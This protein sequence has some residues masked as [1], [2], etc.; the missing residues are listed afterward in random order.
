MVGDTHA[1]F[2]GAHS[3]REYKTNTKNLVA[4]WAALSVCLVGVFLGDALLGDD[5]VGQARAAEPSEVREGKAS[6]L[7]WVGTQW[8]IR[9]ASMERDGGWI[10]FEDAVLSSLSGARAGAGSAWDVRANRV[11]VRLASPGRIAV[12]RAEGR[13]RVIGEAP[14]YV[15]G[16]RAVSF[17]PGRSVTVVGRGGAAQLHGGDWRFAGDRIEVDFRAGAATVVDS[18]SAESL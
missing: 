12:W 18:D 4:F 1:H 15:T 13:V 5:L 8:G 16:D 9:A 11:V 7:S 2:M 14:M 3:G 10:A 17:R 6:A